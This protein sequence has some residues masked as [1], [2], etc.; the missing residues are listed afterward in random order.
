MEQNYETKELTKEEFEQNIE[1]LELQE[2]LRLFQEQVVEDYFATPQVIRLN[3]LEHIRLKCQEITSYE[4]FVQL[5]EEERATMK[6][7]EEPFTHIERIEYRTLNKIYRAV[8]EKE[9][10][11]TKFVD[12]KSKIKVNIDDQK[13]E[14]EPIT[15]KE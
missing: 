4:E 6:A 10:E 5:L 8:I 13:V 1:F 15:F 2:R 9:L 3:Y 11:V 7:K 12:L 14:L